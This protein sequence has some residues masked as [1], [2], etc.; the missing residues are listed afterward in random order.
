[1][2]T[3][4]MSVAQVAYMGGCVGFLLGVTALWLFV[5]IWKLIVRLNAKPTGNH[6]M[7]ARRSGNP[8]RYVYLM[9]AGRV[10]T[11]SVRMTG[12]C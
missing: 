2:V 10:L 6:S 8:D 7:G 1:M 3:L 11:E 4:T 12:Y 9:N 5:E